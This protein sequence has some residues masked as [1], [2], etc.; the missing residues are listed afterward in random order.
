ML[1]DNCYLLLDVHQSA[2]RLGRRRR[3]LRRAPGIEDRYL[4]H[5]RYRAMRR[6]RLLRMELT[7]Y[8]G[9]RVFLQRNARIPALLRPV[10]HQPVLANVEVA[11]PGA[12]T[13]L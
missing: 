13:P 9:K 1:S 7:A 6:A 8:I 3:S 2:R 4:V 10:M 12:T 11:R 5:A